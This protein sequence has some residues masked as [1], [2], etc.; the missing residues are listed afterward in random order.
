MNTE[1]EVYLRI[2]CSFS[3]DDWDDLLP[4]AQLALSNRTSATTGFSSFFLNHG[5]HCEPLEPSDPLAPAGSTVSPAQQGR[6]WATKIKD[7]HDLA[8]AAIADAQETQEKYSNQSRSAAERFQVGDK[9]LLRLRNVTTNRPSKKLD[10]VALPYR[11]TG[12]AGSHAVRLD[13]PPG[14]H[15]VFHVDLLRRAS[16]DPLPSQL[17]QHPEPPAIQPS[18]ASEDNIAGEYKVEK[19]LN[20]RRQGR[21]W[22]V[23]VQWIGWAEPTWEPLRD[24]LDT[25]ALEIYENT[26]LTIPWK[27]EGEGGEG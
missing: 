14:I 20:H 18:Q 19:V 24:L 16:E 10:W 17:I 4:V 6:L 2:F 21:G 8:A 5:F 11:V 26:L 1:L 15:P 27:K 9:V 7:T 13:T 25:E 22:R 12:L 3:Q 23:L